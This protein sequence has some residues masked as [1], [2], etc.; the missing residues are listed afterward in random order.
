LE[1]LGYDFKFICL[2]YL[3]PSIL[4]KTLSKEL[5]IDCNL[6]CAIRALR[7]AWIKNRFTDLV[8]DL[9]YKYRVI[10][11]EKGL[12]EKI[13]EKAYRIIVETEGLRKI[14]KLRKQLPIFFEKNIDV[15]KKDNLLKIGI[16]G[17]MYVV[18]EPS[19]NLDIHK[20]LNELGV[21][22]KNTVSLRSYLDIGLKLNP[23]VKSP[24]KTAIRAAKP[25]IENKCGGE[26]LENVGD[27]VLCKK[28]GY[29]GMVHLYPFTC[30]PEII[31]RS[32]IPQIS[33]EYDTPV[34]SLVVDEHTGE[35]GFHTRIE[36]F[37]DMLVRRKM[38]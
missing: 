23:F 8:D 29:D 37:V 22:V 36:A 25:Y 4:L 17:E 31:T 9:L 34:L 2:D 38:E 12:S 24:Y 14:K 5:G 16:C 18:F 1:D 28:H 33:R 30:M 3:K 11:S 26:T 10:E 21:V 13:A 32:F 6:H 15:Q 27:I 35:A 7:I 19:L 20:K